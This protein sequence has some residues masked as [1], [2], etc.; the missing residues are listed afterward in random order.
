M[1]LSSQ[2]PVVEI[3]AAVAIQMLALRGGRIHRQHW[4]TQAFRSGF[5]YAED[6]EFYV[7]AITRRE[8]GIGH[9]EE[10]RRGPVH[11]MVRV[12]RSAD[13]ASR[14]LSSIEHGWMPAIDDLLA[15]DWV[16]MPNPSD[17]FIRLT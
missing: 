4:Y 2:R 1:E 5:D 15:N 14:G 3:N 6:I 17:N 10:S 16:W 12:K 8:L 11:D 13:A 9:G 7:V